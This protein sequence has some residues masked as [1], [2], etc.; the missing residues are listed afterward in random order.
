MIRNAE[1]ITSTKDGDITNTEIEFKTEN[2]SHKLLIGGACNVNVIKEMDAKLIVSLLQAIVAMLLYNGK[3]IHEQSTQIA[4]LS[5]IS[6][7]SS[8][9]SCRTKSARAQSS[10]AR[11][12]TV[13][14]L[15][16]LLPDSLEG[17]NLGN[18]RDQRQREQRQQS[19]GVLQ[20]VLWALSI[21]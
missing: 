17:V 1:S 20:A 16:A 13:P 6:Q 3:I 18:R 2:P 12:N 19:C 7:P 9:C 4:Q 21:L 10:A 14:Q 15:T 11:G 8:E 5:K